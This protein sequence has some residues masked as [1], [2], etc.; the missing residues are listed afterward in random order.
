MSN[1][2]R[3]RMVSEIGYSLLFIE[4]YYDLLA[5]PR[6]GDIAETYSFLDYD[7]ETGMATHPVCGDRVCVE[8]Y[9]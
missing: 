2:V 1:V 8:D 6:A 5:S 7:P 4:E 9:L 3:I